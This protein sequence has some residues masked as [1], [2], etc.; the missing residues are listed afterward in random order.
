MSPELKFAVFQAAIIVPFLIGSVQ[1]NSLKDS[2]KLSSRLI[3]LNILLLDPVIILWSIWGLNLSFDMIFLPLAGLILVCGG[4]MI[5][6]LTS[7]ILL[8][9]SKKRAVFVISSSLANHGFTMGGFLSYFF[10]GEKGIALSAI[11]L[12][13]FTPFTFLFI[14][15]YAR[16]KSTEDNTF[17]FKELKAVFFNIKN[18]PLYAAVTAILLHVPGIERPDIYFPIDVILIFCVALNYYCLGLNFIFSDVKSGKMESVILAVCKFMV[19]PLIAWVILSFVNLGPDIEAVIMLQ[20]FMPAA[21][22]SVVASLLF[23][24]DSNMA[25]RL[26]VI[27]TVIFIL[28]ILP[29]LFFAGPGMLRP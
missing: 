5:G 28:I 10:L 16:K 9:D 22:Y 12:I 8:K 20:S 15:P 29:L 24:L 6:V 21:V 25:S 11:F 7:P 17:S 18:M 23:G 4:F 3:Y 14:F 19:I 27:N 26:F 2:E 1:R 13:Y